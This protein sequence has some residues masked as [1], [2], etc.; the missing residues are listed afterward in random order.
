MLTNLS[1]QENFKL[2]FVAYFKLIIYIVFIS[3]SILLNGEFEIFE[4]YKKWYKVILLFHMKN[5]NLA[6]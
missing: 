3:K 6:S 1:F 4:T 5:Y 2:S